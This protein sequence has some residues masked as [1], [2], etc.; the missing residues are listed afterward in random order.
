MDSPPPPRDRRGMR[1]GFTTGTNAAAAAHAA[2]LALLSGVWP[3]SVPVLLPTGE[4]TT[5]VPLET[6]LNG[7]TASCCVRKDGGDDPDV[8]HGALICATVRSASQPGLWLEGG[9]GVG[10]VT[11]PGLGLPVGEAAINPVPRQQIHANVMAALETLLPDAAAYLEQHGLLVEISVPE[12]ERLAQRTLNPRLGIVGGISILGTSGKVYPYS[13]AAWR[14][15][16]E[17]AVQLGAYHS[18]HHLVL[19][20]GARSEQYAQQ[21]YPQ[22]PE[23]A[24]VE[25]S[26]FTGVAL[27]ACVQQGVSK[28]SL[29]AMISRI[30]KTA[31]GRMVTHV[32]GNPVDFAFLA[33]VCGEA[34]ASAALVAA[35][36]Q[37]NTARHMLELCQAH[38]NMAPI[39]RLTDLA[40]EQSQRFVQRLGGQ[41]ALEMILVDFDG[42]VLV[43]RSFT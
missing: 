20:T 16:V 28:A 1:T 10:R 31:Q 23:L 3:T 4:T 32:A 9:H 19:A 37:A 39:E 41:L 18:P 22:L 43:R 26:I 17:Q 11:L 34:G 14:A 24:F 15:S 35:V 25:I 30:V 38:G 42:T 36:A 21:I 13:T 27:R 40:L 2:T 8:T 33:Q 6:A 12:G 29:V 7:Q 5:M